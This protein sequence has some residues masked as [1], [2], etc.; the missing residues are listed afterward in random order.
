MKKYLIFVLSILAFGCED[1][2]ALPQ[3]SFSLSNTLLHPYED[4]VITNNSDENLSY[5]WFVNGQH[6][7]IYDDVKEPSLR[8][9]HP[10]EYTL[11]MTATNLSGGKKSTD[12]Q[13]RIGNYQITKLVVTEIQGLEQHIWDVDSIGDAQWPDLILM[14]EI[15]H[16]N[17][18]YR[19]STYWNTSS[20]TLPLTIYTPTDFIY[21]SQDIN[22]I[23]FAFFDDDSDTVESMSIR[24]GESYLNR[25][26]DSKTK[27]GSYTVF[28]DGGIIYNLHYKII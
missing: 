20:S 6:L 27:L 23:E 3:V 19:G 2:I 12:A 1:E 28:Q 15:G 13:F 22:S 25:L 26:Y 11:R 10:G 5:Q 16:Q 21:D 14:R 17:I 18:S 24:S 9:N 7:S 4:L 8:M